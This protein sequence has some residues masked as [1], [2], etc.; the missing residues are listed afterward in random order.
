M[1]MYATARATMS[2]GTWGSD[3][4]KYYNKYT[5]KNDLD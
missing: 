2:D 5:K 4:G 3:I 1:S